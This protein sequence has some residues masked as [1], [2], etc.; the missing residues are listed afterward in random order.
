MIAENA[1][2]SGVGW[3]LW[4][5]TCSFTFFFFFFQKSLVYM[6]EMTDNLYAAVQRNVKDWQA[7]PACCHANHLY[8]VL[9]AHNKAVLLVMQFDV[10]CVST[11]Y[12]IV[13]A[14][15]WSWNAPGHTTV[16]GDGHVDAATRRV[17]LV[18]G[19]QLGGNACVQRQKT[20]DGC[21]AT[22]CRWTSV[23]VLSIESDATD[24]TPKSSGRVHVRARPI[25]TIHS[26]H[27]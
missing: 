19:T 10:D 26:V 3:F 22:S 23:F 21:C 18:D 25:L 4:C 9:I 27:S 14:H 13:T 20:I 6:N 16:V 1:L 24:C 11:P 12:R 7:S 8:M 15:C 17:A 5:F 2:V